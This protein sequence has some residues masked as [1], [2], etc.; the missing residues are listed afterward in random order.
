MN[1][2]IILF[3]TVVFCAALAL[4]LWTRKSITAFEQRMEE[5]Q[6]ASHVMDDITAINAGT[7]GLGS[8]FLRLE[9]E[10]QAQ[11]GRVDE[12]YTRIQTNTPYA[13]AI[14]LAQKGASMDEIIDLCNI[15][16]SEAQLLL[17][18]HRRDQAA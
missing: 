8:R 2:L 10:L 11:A 13:Q 17:M 1:A 16:P 6:A 3:S 14:H 5:L 9:K 18:M 7:I 12:L 15:S 4:W